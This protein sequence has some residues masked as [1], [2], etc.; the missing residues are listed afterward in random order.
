MVVNILRKKNKAYRWADEI[1]P[2]P[3]QVEINV[4]D[5]V[6]KYMYVIHYSNIKYALFASQSLQNLF[7]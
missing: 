6:A 1:D 2:N 5:S 3:E 7:R 4:A